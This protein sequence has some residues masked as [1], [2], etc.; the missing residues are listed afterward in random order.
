MDTNDDGCMDDIDEHRRSTDTNAGGEL[1]SSAAVDSTSSNR[2]TNSNS[3][4]AE[5]LQRTRLLPAYQFAGMSAIFDHHKL[6][7]TCLKFA[8]NHK[9]LF[10][11]G[12]LDGQ[13]S[14]C[15][16][17]EQAAL[18]RRFLLTGHEGGVTDL[19][20]SR[21]NDMLMSVSLDKCVRLWDMRTGETLRVIRESSEILCGAFCP[22][23]NNFFAVRSVHCA[24]RLLS[25]LMIS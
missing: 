22:V 19:E 4:S 10:A 16:V 1:G 8:N 20:W 9:Y 13:V 3:T 24:F 2:P 12:S 14:V 25:K 21:N 7:V 18:E 23:N 15:T 6:A 5:E 11:C 17:A